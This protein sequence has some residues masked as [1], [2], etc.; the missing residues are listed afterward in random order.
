MYL[1]LQYIPSPRSIYSS[2]RKLPP[3]HALTWQD[4]KISVDRYWDLPIGQPPITNDFEE[5]KGLLRETLVE[6][7]RLRMISDVPLGAFLS[8]GVDS[9]IIVALMSGLSSKPVKTFSIGFD[10]ERFSEITY[11]RLIAERYK[12]DHCEFIV[13]PEM[14]DV[15]PK[16][17]WHYGEPYADA[18]ALPEYYVAR[19]TRKFVTVA[20][21]GDGGDENFGGYVRYFAMKAARLG[22]A[23]RALRSACGVAPEFLPEHDAPLGNV[24]RAKR[25]LRST[26][27]TTSPGRHLKMIGYFPRTTS[28]CSI[29]TQF[30][31][32]LGASIGEAPALHAARLRGLRGRGFRQPHAL[33]GLQDL[34]SGMPDGQGGRRHEW[35]ALSRGV[36]RCSTMCS[37]R[38]PSVCRATG[39]SRACAAIS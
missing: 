15:L 22:L 5:A 9:S 7:T 38:R 12:T 18:S 6:S 23:A 27:S 10:E 1:T 11:A 34:S 39:S 29:P 19:E 24:W 21:N 4:G 13:K 35:P 17:A 32:R 36:R 20:L 25:F 2:V 3:A 30:K 28:P 37:W 16:L 26:L 31:Q 14:A 8:G 33:R